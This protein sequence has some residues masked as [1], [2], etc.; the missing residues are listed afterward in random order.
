MHGDTVLARPLGRVQRL[1]G[2]PDE[3][4]GGGRDVFGQGGDA[5]AR[6]DAAAMG[7]L[8]RGQHVADTI[9]VEAG[10]R[11]G[12]FHEQDGELVPAVAADDVDAA[13]MAHENLRHAPERLVAR[14]VAEIVVHRFE[15]VEVEEHHRHGVIEAAIA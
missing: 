13:G 1:V 7:E 8:G 10:P 11:L 12:R 4:V 14:G 3:V 5:E 15:A 6:G 2:G 9:R